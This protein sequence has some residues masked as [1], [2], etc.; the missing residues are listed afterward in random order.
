MEIEVSYANIERHPL[1]SIS[2]VHRG[3]YLGYATF[4]GHMIT[5]RIKR[6]GKEW[7][8]INVAG[9]P[10]VRGKSLGEISS[11]LYNIQLKFPAVL[12]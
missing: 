4:K 1:F 5:Y 9:A 11:A 10:M 7:Q 8:G 2:Y 12:S 3:V 6:N